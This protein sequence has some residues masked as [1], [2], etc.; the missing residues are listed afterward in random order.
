MATAPAV[1]FDVDGTLV[2]SELSARS[3]VVPGVQRSHSRGGG[4]ADTQVDRHG[5]LHAGV[6]AGRGRR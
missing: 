4:V 2:D 6:I 3:R 5:R 1:L